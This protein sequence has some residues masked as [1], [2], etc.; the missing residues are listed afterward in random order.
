MHDLHILG[1]RADE[2]HLT[3]EDVPQLRDLVELPTAQ[4]APDGEDARITARR[5]PPRP[6]IEVHRPQLQHLEG[7]TSQSRALG[8]VEHGPLAGTLDTDRGEDHQGCREHEGDG[9]HH[10]V[11]DPSH[12]ASTIW[13]ASRMRSPHLSNARALVK[14]CS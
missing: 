13:A 3:P 12:H 5:D 4:R 2:R 7:P 9:R 14:R 11:H 1:P 10:D 8:P 6:P